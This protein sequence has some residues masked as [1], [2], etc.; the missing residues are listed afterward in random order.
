MAQKKRIRWR[1]GDVVSIDLGDGH[2]AF[3]RVLKRPLV[4]FYDLRAPKPPP[5]NEILQ[6][7][8]LFKLNVM[9]YAIKEGDW[10]VIGHAPLE[11]SLQK[12]PLFFKQD[13]IT[14]RLYIYQDSGRDLPATF[15]EVAGLEVAA[16]WEPHHVVERLNDHFAGRP[17]R[18]LALHLPKPVLS[19]EA[20]Q[21]RLKELDR[22]MKAF[23][24]LGKKK[25]QGKK[26]AAPAKR[27]TPT[28]GKGRKR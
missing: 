26:R 17:F 4:A 23:M 11:E 18:R 3:G 13:P 1:E 12:Q 6:H 16:A 22:R 10:P 24:A 25:T 21:E 15:E 5:I 27:A 7:R 20:Q 2:L 9:H 19:E 8:V 14:T 28:R